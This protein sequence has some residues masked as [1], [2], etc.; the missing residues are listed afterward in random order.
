[1]VIL[2]SNYASCYYLPY[3]SS[4]PRFVAAFLAP[5]VAPQ[6]VVPQSPA[7]VKVSDVVLP[8]LAAAVSGGDD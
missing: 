6:G 3:L 4:S 1:M 8:L 7:V 5:F 2:R